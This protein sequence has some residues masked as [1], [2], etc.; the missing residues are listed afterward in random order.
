MLGDR[1]QLHNQ[2]QKLQ[3]RRLYRAVADDA[4]GTNYAIRAPMQHHAINLPAF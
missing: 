4:V 3:G 1:L 2:T